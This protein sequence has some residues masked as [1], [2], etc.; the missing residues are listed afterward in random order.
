MAKRHSTTAEALQIA[1]EMGAYRTVL[2]HFS[3]RYPK[4]P[5]GL[6][7][8]G[9][10]N[11]IAAF[12]GMTVPLKCLEDL[13]LMLPALQA[14]LREVDESAAEAQEGLAQPETGSEAV[15]PVSHLGGSAVREHGHEEAENEPNRRRGPTHVRFEH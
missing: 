13:P 7:T 6:E 5:P 15:N 12:D 8:W 1:T 14:A 11:A 3:Q 9:P 10:A 2:T 4:L